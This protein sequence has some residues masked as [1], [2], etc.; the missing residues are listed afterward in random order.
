ML[1]NG[2]VSKQPILPAHLD[3]EQAYIAHLYPHAYLSYYCFGS[4][5]QL[6]ND[7]AKASIEEEKSV[8]RRVGVVVG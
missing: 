6:Y 4:G 7:I 3:T 8:L 2:Y 5:H 1:V